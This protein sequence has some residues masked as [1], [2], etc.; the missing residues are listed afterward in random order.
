MFAVAASLIILSFLTIYVQYD[1]LEDDQVPSL[2]QNDN[3]IQNVN[4]F[5]YFSV[6]IDLYCG[7]F[8]FGK[9]VWLFFKNFYVLFKKISVT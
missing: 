8:S 2:M 1:L 4:C 3:L 7:A 6:F 9:Q 5:I